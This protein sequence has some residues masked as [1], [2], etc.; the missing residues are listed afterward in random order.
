I[1]YLSYSLALAYKMRRGEI[2]LERVRREPKPEILIERKEMSN[3]IKS[4]IS[5]SIKLGL[6][7]LIVS[8]I[9]PVISGITLINLNDLALSSD[10]LLSILN[11]IVIIYFGYRIMLALKAMIDVI[12]KRLVGAVGITE[13]TLKH[14]LVDCL[15]IV[16]AALLWVY[17][18]PQLG[19]YMG[20]WAS[21]LAA[22][23]IF[24]FFLLIL[25]DLAKLLYMTFGD[26]YKEIVEKI[27]KKLHEGSQ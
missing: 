23:I 17:L 3:T 16:L 10:H 22:L 14:I 21:R 27:A 9:A 1:F 26:F 12:A 24:V 11:L 8:M 6:A 20:E 18:P 13:T 15:Y 2:K 19:I 25:Y 7:L 4:L 5:N